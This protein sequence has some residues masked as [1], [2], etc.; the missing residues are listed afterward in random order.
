MS[1]TYHSSAALV[2]VQTMGLTA[3]PYLPLLERL[4]NDSP[5][6][7]DV[8]ALIEGKEEDLCALLF[9]AVST[10]NNSAV[11]ATFL[12]LF[13][14]LVRL[15]PVLGEKLGAPQA[16]ATEEDDPVK[17]LLYLAA[18][19][20]MDSS[21]SIPAMHLVA[22]ALRYG[23]PKLSERSLQHFFACVTE[24]LTAEPLQVDI[25][26]PVVQQCSIVAHRK[27]LRHYFFDNKL[28]QL[29]PRL[30]T[31]TVGED[32]ASIVQ[33]TYEVLVL[34]WLLS[35]EFEGVVELQAC[36]II[37]HL[38]RVLQRMQKEKCIRVTLMTLWNIVEAERLFVSQTANPS[39][40]AWVDENM[41]SL[42]RANDGRGP[43]FVAEMVGVGMLK[44]LTQLSHRK[45]GDED[46]ATL[47]NDLLNVLENSMEKLTSF[48][49]YRGEVLSG[50]LEWTP[51]HT[52]AKF[53]QNNVN[54]IEKNSYE[55]L[56]ALG[57]LLM[58]S[59]DDC[60]L[61]VACYDLG[62]IVRH[63]PTGRALL[64]LPQMQGVM[65]QVMALMSHEKSEV[66][67]NALLAVQ[68]ILV[69]RWEYM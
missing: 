69:Q 14:D 12:Q 10:A 47:T 37:P 25:V 3:K 50:R 35:Y 64:Q 32:A 66:A 58:S 41:F 7:G 30:L 45:F 2:H 42:G 63:H 62:E 15:S 28:V 43:A 27:E 57:D 40:T 19:Y 55:V 11:M 34:S 56:A 68:K 16:T 59:S 52:S 22:V 29:I 26:G 6:S 48:S 9:K 60:T 49:E 23:D 51:V 36:K 31:D 39:N 5:P 21:I 20:S 17:T 53:W 4:L 67:K 46:I 44:T 61:A 33:F 38:H 13:A 18:T 8:Q 65:A 1:C 54:Q 24:M